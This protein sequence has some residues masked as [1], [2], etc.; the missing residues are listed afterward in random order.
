MLMAFSDDL[1]FV[2]RIERVKKKRERAQV[3]FYYWGRTGSKAKFQISQGYNFYF[4]SY[5]TANAGQSVNLEN[6]HIQWY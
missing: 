1:A 2:I 4:Y 5:I 6:C 3:G